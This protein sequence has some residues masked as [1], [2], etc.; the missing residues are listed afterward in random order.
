MIQDEWRIK[1]VWLSGDHL[2]M[3]VVGGLACTSASKTFFPLSA[4]LTVQSRRPNSCSKMIQPHWLKYEL[5]LGFLI[6][7]SN[8]HFL[9]TDLAGAEWIASLFSFSTICSFILQEPPRPD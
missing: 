5:W 3:S 8:T 9:L 1:A 7:M 6:F 4:R 2:V